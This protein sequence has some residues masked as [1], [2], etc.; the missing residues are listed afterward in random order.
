M[1]E[2]VK[3]SDDKLEELINMSPADMTDQQ[4]E[5]YL[6]HIRHTGIKRQAARKERSAARKTAKATR[7]NK[8]I[9]DLRM[10]LEAEGKTSTVIEQSITILKQTLGVK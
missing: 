9:R 1:T 6:R 8:A 7:E 10:R 2:I 3:A 5:T 4:L